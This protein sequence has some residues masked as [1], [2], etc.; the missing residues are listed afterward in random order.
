MPYISLFHGIVYFVESW[1]FAFLS[2]FLSA[3]LWSKN[4]VIHTHV[5]FMKT[6]ILKKRYT[7][8]YSIPRILQKRI[9][10]RRRRVPNQSSRHKRRSGIT[11]RF[12]DSVASRVKTEKRFALKEWEWFVF[13]Q[14]SQLP[15]DWMGI[16][17]MAKTGY[18]FFLIILGM[19]MSYNHHGWSY[20]LHTINVQ[21]FP[22]VSGYNNTHMITAHNTNT[23]LSVIRLIY[24]LKTMTG[25][26]FKKVE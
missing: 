6:A 21:I 4:P 13:D 23:G 8:S 7:C 20:N 15:W 11:N 22:S 3:K 24:F 5:S 16:V 17:S 12:F 18:E 1:N 10:K 14:I 19:G 26:Q 25:R 2:P 9:K